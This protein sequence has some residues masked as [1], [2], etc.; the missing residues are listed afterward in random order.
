MK[1]PTFRHH[2]VLLSPVNSPR[3]IREQRIPIAPAPV[4]IGKAVACAL[5]AAAFGFLLAA[6]LPL[7]AQAQV[8]NLLFRSGYEPSTTINAVSS[9]NCWPTP[10][11]CWQNITGTDTT[12]GYTWPPSIW[13]GGGSAFLLLADTPGVTAANIGDY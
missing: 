2:R 3:L 11:G 5:R 12:T 8:P 1:Y 10:S 6:G 13:G 7:V 4:P 9:S